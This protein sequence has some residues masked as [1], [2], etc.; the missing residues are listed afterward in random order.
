MSFWETI[1]G[2]KA[3]SPSQPSSDSF[4]PDSPSP[5]I[6]QF[7]PTTLP[8]S[9]EIFSQPSFDPSALHPLAGLNAESLDY[10]TL[11]EGGVSDL[12]GGRSR[13]LPSRGWADDLCYGTGVTYLSGLCIGGAWGMGEGLR[14]SQGVTA[15]KLRLNS[16][17]NSVTRR[18][19]FLGNSAG[20]IAVGLFLRVQK[21]RLIR[22]DGL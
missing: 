17:L 22:S 13:A 1:T 11:E 10:L 16:V 20:I 19:P 6:Q 14:K 9:Q 5:Q 3:P 18:G 12:P 8:S 15:P 4:S 21:R 7:D 2:K